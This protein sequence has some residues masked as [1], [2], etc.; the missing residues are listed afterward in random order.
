MK[1]ALV[2]WSLD[3]LDRVE[4]AVAA[5]VAD[6]RDVAQA[7]EHRP[8]LALLAQHVAA[9]VLALEDVE[10]GHRDRGGDR[11]P[12]EGEAVRERLL[13][14]GERLVDLGRRRSSRPSARRRRSAPSPW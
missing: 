8:E 3:Q 4:E 7:V 9:E 1:P 6:D 11:V 5:D 12:A 10:V 14:V 2:S 13:A